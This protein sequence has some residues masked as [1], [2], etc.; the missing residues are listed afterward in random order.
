MIVASGENRVCI[1]LP[2]P[3]AY[4]A[5]EAEHRTYA[6]IE[7]EEFANKQASVKR[8]GAGREERLEFHSMSIT[9]LVENRK[10]CWAS[11]HLRLLGDANERELH[12]WSETLW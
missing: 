11:E 4:S 12:D 2:T 8:C 1:V 3:D 9:L 7:C 6:H 10:H 5:D